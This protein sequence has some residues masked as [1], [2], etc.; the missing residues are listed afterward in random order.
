MLLKELDDW[1][2]QRF[3]IDA[4]QKS[5]PGM[6]GVQVGRLDKEVTRVAFAVDACMESFKRAAAWQA[7]L[8]LVHHGL[9]WGGAYPL[10]GPAYDRIECLVKNNLALYAMHLPLD[11]HPELGN[12]IGLARQLGLADIL[13]F[14]TWRGA[15]IGFKGT[16]PTPLRIEEVVI[17][18]F[19]DWRATLGSLPFGKEHNRTVGI[20]SGGATDEVDQ[21]IAEGLDLFITGDSDHTLYHRCLEAGINVIFGGHY[22]TEIWGVS[23]LARHLRAETGLETCFIDLPTGF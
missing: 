14:G 12:N 18:V 4:M 7:D 10:C 22:Q 2:R 5:D 21:A 8:L 15:S 1:L 16:L 19:G 3:A 23:Q 11:A 13:P 17:K 6:N 20:V 9:Y